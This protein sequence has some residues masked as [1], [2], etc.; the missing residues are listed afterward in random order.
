MP[1]PIRNNAQQ[2]QPQ[3]QQQQQQQQQP[4]PRTKISAE[5]VKKAYA[6]SE[7]L[8]A[9]KTYLFYTGEFKAV[10][11]TSPKGTKYSSITLEMAD[12]NYNP[13]GKTLQ[14]LYNNTVLIVD[15]VISA[16][17]GIIGEKDTNGD[18]DVM[19]DVI[20]ALV[21]KQ[22]PNS[23]GYAVVDVQASVEATIELYPA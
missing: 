3:Q 13:T 8:A 1:A 4:A 19:Q 7:R 17:A 12:D 9:G 14:L 22:D 5:I 18:L 2:Q 10:E 21:T 20:F 6:Q 16:K 15:G 11:K 23:N